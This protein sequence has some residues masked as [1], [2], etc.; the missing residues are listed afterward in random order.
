MTKAL[1]LLGFG[2][3]DESDASWE[4]VQDVGLVLI[5]AVV[6][7]RLISVV[8]GK[9]AATDGIIGSSGSG[10]QSSTVEGS[11]IR[12]DQN[13]SI[14]G[15]ISLSPATRFTVT[16]ER[17]A[18]WHAGAYDRYTGGG[19]ARSGD[20]TTYSGLLSTP[21]GETT[22][23]EQQ[24]RAE[25]TIQTMP[26]AW[27]PVELTDAPSG[28]VRVTPS[29]DLQPAQPFSG[30]D[31]YTVVSEVPDWTDD[32]LRDA[33]TDYPERI[34]ERYLQVPESTPDRVRRRAIELTANA[35][36]PYDAASVLQQWLENN[37]EY[38]LDISRPSGNIADAFIFEMDRGYCV[39]YATAM[40]MMLRIL[41]IPARFA[42]G[43][44]PGQRVADDR[45]VVRGYDSHAWVD[46]YYPESGWIPFD[47]TP[48][49]PRQEAEQTRLGQA[50]DAN[51]SGVDTNETQP[52]TPVS[53]DSSTM[54]DANTT[55]T[56]SRSLTKNQSRPVLAG[57]R[58]G[59]PSA[60]N[61]DEL[62]AGSSE[63]GQSTL[64]P[65]DTNDSQLSPNGSQAGGSQS[66]VSLPIPETDR[67]RITMLASAV[68]AGLGVYR[69]GL[70][71]RGYEAF[72]LR[73]QPR[74]E[75]PD[76]DVTRAFE[77][78][79]QLLSRRY[80]KRRDGETA[81]SYLAALD[82][83]RI[84]ARAYQIVDIYESVQYAGDVSR[85]EADT[86]IEL[87]NEL[88]KGQGVI[89]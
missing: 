54:A 64:S 6:A 11:L 38:S 77:R 28:D 43:Y 82:T 70:L 5:V 66:N 34:R 87:V 22:T 68:G 46:V 3:L 33:G 50:R 26:A 24:F 25:A 57:D 17:S 58:S 41:G 15:S 83:E 88:A 19:W 40:A 60:P 39:Y 72:R 1:G 13:I 44:T 69:F 89:L 18:Y 36:N 86:A 12:A 59:N 73:W 32:Q 56:Q 37:K 4:N 14:L 62:V 7:S 78:L 65:S 29:G 35:Q 71:E 47:P 67:D 81:R 2:G 61:R 10:S 51:E 16:A 45:W 23:N 84:D 20:A 55:S 9:N 21:P 53:P 74:T 85:S 75:S 76:A 27:K 63:A 79:E 31:G 80:R 42:V 30:G 8:P 48:A 52:T 49:G